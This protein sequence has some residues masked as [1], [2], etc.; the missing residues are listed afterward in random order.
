MDGVTGKIVSRRHLHEMR[1][2]P[3]LEFHCGLLF[4]QGS[5]FRV[6]VFENGE[7]RHMSAAA[8]RRAARE[9]I[10]D[11]LKDAELGELMAEVL[12]PAAEALTA[13]AD[14]L[15]T[16]GVAGSEPEGHA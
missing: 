2:V 14:R 7:L 9:M 10:A 15:D 8:A 3:E 11:A 4:V 6:G 5:G 12:K 1:S 16:F 13:T